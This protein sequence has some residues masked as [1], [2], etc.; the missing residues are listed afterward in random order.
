MRV[1]VEVDGLY[2]YPDVVITRGGPKLLDSHQDTLLNPCVI[3][4]ILS[5][6]T[7]DYD[8]GE[9][10]ER[11]RQMAT[12]REY[13]LVAQDRVSV[14]RFHREA[15]AVGTDGPV[16]GPRICSSSNQSTTEGQALRSRP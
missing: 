1:C 9:K 7:E 4:E 14:E 3:I 12:P 5:P 2:T 15:A 16:N 11:Y 13:V 8:R 10:F 6:S